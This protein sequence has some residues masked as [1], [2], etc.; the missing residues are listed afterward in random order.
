MIGKR[1]ILQLLDEFLWFVLFS[2]FNLLN[3]AK[4]NVKL[5]LGL[6][7]TNQYTELK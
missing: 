7:S 4:T 3:K 5:P 6:I 2:F 1:L